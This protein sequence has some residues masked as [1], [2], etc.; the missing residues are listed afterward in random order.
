[1]VHLWCVHCFHEQVC[2]PALNIIVNDSV[3]NVWLS[4]KDGSLGALN[5]LHDSHMS[6]IDNKV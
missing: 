3:L 4:D 2:V 6:A 1:M 5:S